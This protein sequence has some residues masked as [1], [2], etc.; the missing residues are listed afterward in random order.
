MSTVGT[1][2][3]NLRTRP[4]N[5]TTVGE[6]TYAD[7]IGAKVYRRDHPAT[8]KWAL[9]D[10]ETLRHRFGDAWVKDL[11]LPVPTPLLLGLRTLCFEEAERKAEGRLKYAMKRLQQEDDRGDS[12]FHPRPPAWEAFSATTVRKGHPGSNFEETRIIRRLRRAGAM[13]DYKGVLVPVGVLRVDLF[14]ESGVHLAECRA[15]AIP[16]PELKA[17][18]SR[19]LAVL[20]GGLFTPLVNPTGPGFDRLTRELQTLGRRHFANT[21]FL[22]VKASG[23]IPNPNAKSGVSQRELLLALLDPQGSRRVVSGDKPVLQP[24]ILTYTGERPKGFLSYFEDVVLLRQFVFRDYKTVTGF[25]PGMTLC[26]SAC[27]ATSVVFDGITV[28]KRDLPQALDD[29]AAWHAMYGAFHGTAIWHNLCEIWDFDQG[30]VR[31]DF[32]LRNLIRDPEEYHW[33]PHVHA[34]LRLG[35]YGLQES[36]YLDLDEIDE[37][38]DTDEQEPY[39]PTT[40]EPYEAFCGT[41]IPKMPAKSGT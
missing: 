23:R 16:A 26:D 33:M 37:P 13:A 15:D 1:F 22:L 41:S 21:R 30:E 34:S 7:L 36:G 40:W 9:W 25:S 10:P 35:G 19:V 39:D 5:Q 20:S 17:A 27:M 31:A 14:K 11:N 24:Q 3:R 32:E 29:E 2:V 12:L 28:R 38:S 18:P 8:W 4:E 6:K